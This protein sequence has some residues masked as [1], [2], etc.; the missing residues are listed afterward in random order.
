MYRPPRNFSTPLENLS[1]PPPENFSTPLEN[2]STPPPENFSPPPKKKK[3]SQ[4]PTPHPRKY[5]NLTRKKSQSKK[6][7]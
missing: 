5:P 1:T 2:L 6:I 7:C 3:N 4:S